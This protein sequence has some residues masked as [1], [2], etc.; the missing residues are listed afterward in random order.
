[1]KAAVNIFVAGKGHA[2]LDQPLNGAA[3]MA[4]GVAHRRFIAQATTGD[5]GVLHVR[6]NAVALI[7]HG[8]HTALRPKGRA[9]GE[10]AF[11]QHG[12]TYVSGQVK[13]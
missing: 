5:E 6:I 13:G 11:A 2:L 3:A 12:D 7:Q 1:M 9:T 10:L 8:C 4:H